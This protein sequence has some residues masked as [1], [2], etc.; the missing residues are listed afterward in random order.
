MNNKKIK[1][2]V[3]FLISVF[4]FGCAGI[5]HQTIQEKAMQ[6]NKNDGISIEE[7]ALVAQSK[8]IEEGKVQKFHVAAPLTKVQ[9]L[10]NVW[11]VCFKEKGFFSDEW[12]CVYVDKEIG[13][14]VYFSER[15][16]E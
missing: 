2:G 5:S 16:L 10:S 9:H 1:V 14:V 7:A 13:T 15:E 3:A 11:T 6:I 4:C 12:I 8:I